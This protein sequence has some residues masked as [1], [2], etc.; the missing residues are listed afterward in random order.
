MSE[1]R[2]RRSLEVMRYLTGVQTI[3]L[4]FL[5]LA[6]PASAQSPVLDDLMARL[7]RKHEIPGGQLAA[8]RNGRLIH[9]AGYGLSDIEN[10]KAVRAN[11]LFRIGSVSKTITQIAVMTLVDKGVLRLEDKAFVILDSLAPPK[12]A[13]PDSRLLDITVLHL[14]KHQGGWSEIEPMFPP[15]SRTAAAVLGSPEP[16]DCKIIIRYMMG[17]PLDYTPGTNTVYSNFGY[18]VLGRIIERVSGLPYDE[19]VKRSVLRPAG[20]RDMKIGGTRLRERVRRE[21]LY[22]HQFNQKELPF[23]TESVFPGEG[24][25]PWAYGGYYLRATDAHGGWIGSAHDIVRIAEAIDGRMGHVIL[26]PASRRILMNLPKKPHDEAPD[27]TPF[28][29]SHAGA[30][31]GSNAALLYRTRDGFSVGLTFNS[32][33]V[34]YKGFFADL[35]DQVDRALAALAAEPK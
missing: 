15:W 21:V 22:F 20:I 31:Q 25:V 35:M 11:S 10:R 12:G 14:L 5:L 27:G 33:P 32:L 17:R 1:N 30:L 24:K 18:C 3:V 9:N 34:D 13:S 23:E 29:I 26:S 7:L 4:S 2:T 8:A 16:P 28:H 6:P 19:Y